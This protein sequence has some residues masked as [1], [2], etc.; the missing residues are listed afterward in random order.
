MKAIPVLL[1]AGLEARMVKLPGGEDPDSFVRKRGAK[2][3]EDQL[4]ASR[5]V[6]EYYFG[7]I[8]T[9]QSPDKLSAM[10][11]AVVPALAAISTDNTR[12]IMAS[13]FAKGMNVEYAVLEHALRAH[14]AGQ[15]RPESPQRS[16]QSVV[17][18]PSQE[19]KVFALLADYPD[20]LP[21]AEQLGIGSLL[22]DARLRDMY[23]AALA[24]R[25][26]L[27]CAP[28]EL[29]DIVAEH[30]L[31]GHFRTQEKDPRTTLEGVA[32]TLRKERRDAEAREL[33]RQIDDAKRR[34]DSALVRQL[35]VRH[36]ETL[37]EADKAG[38]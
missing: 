38:G 13:Q 21:Y 16:H 31:A 20:L 19:L 15:S 3:F 14:A 8:W 7:E 36:H 28:P 24:G 23:S 25:P 2:A 4:A 17:P 34:G 26:L 10:M 35:V 18:P 27:D 11:R 9:D 29:S 37:K 12:F 33:R 30:V 32:G 22:T 1:A 6:V 5:N